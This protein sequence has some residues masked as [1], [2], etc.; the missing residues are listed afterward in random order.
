MNPATLKISAAVLSLIGSGLLAWRVKGILEALA[1]VVK[2]HEVNIQ[3]L[4]RPS[5]DIYNLANSTEHVEN[6]QQYG[7]LV[8]GFLC[9]IASAALQLIS[10]LVAS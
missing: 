2:A 10:L 3:Q 5:G 1:L 7:L 8:L 6:A 9:L 4:M